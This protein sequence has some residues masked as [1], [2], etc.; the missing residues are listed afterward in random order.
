MR[1]ATSRLNTTA[2]SGNA[3]PVSPLASV[4]RSGRPA[5]PWRCHANHSPQ[6]PKALITSSAMRYTPRSAVARR[7]AGQYES[8]ATMPLVPALG[9][10]NTAATCSAPR[11]SMRS[12]IACAARTP[13]SSASRLPN[14]QRYAYGGGT[15]CTPNADASTCA[16]VRESPDRAIARCVAP[17]YERSR[18]ITAPRGLREACRA[19]FTAFSLASAPPRVKNT[20]PPSKPERSSNISAR[21]ARGRAPHAL[22]TKH[23]CAAC[24]RMAATNFGCWCP[25]LLHSARLLMSRIVRPS[26]RCSRA[27]APPTTVGACQSAWTDQLCRTEW[28]SSIDIATASHERVCALCARSVRI[29]HHSMKHLPS[30]SIRLTKGWA[31]MAKSA[32]SQPAFEDSRDY[33]QS[34]ARGLAVLRAFDAEHTRL[35]LAEIAHRAGT[36]RAS[37]RRLIMTLEHLGY[38][39]LSGREYV[40]SPSV[41]E[42]GFGYL[43]SLNLTDLAQ[44]L[45]Q[46]L[47]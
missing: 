13:Q 12:A 9:S 31:S 2:P 23:S 1:A 45:L 21:R 10:I 5:S 42:L 14:G 40:L 29:A 19:I 11:M 36:S 25:R 37:A 24:A 6:R 30:S 39:R 34:L 27:P 16:C 28:R 43:G 4:T 38:V 46:D 35:S 33:V 17:W 15:C 26:A 41:L 20:R 22:L 18:A 3:A 7:N 44:P 32:R 8:G 47:P